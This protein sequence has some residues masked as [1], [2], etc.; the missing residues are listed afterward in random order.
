MSAKAKRLNQILEILAQEGEAEVK[1]LSEQLGVSP[2]TIRKDL[3]ELE[4]KTLIQREHGIARLRS[5]DNVAGRIAYHYDTK[6]KLAKRAA[7]LVH[8]GETVMIESG[9]CCALLAEELA[10]TKHDVTIVTNSAF[11]ADFIRHYNNINI[12][13]LGGIYEKDAQV[14]TGPLVSQ[15]AQNYFVHSFFIGTDGYSE[16]TGFTNNNQLRAQAVRDMAK[17]CDRLIILTESE[18]FHQHGS[19]PLNV[20]SRPT[21]VI[22]DSRIESDTAHTLKAHG[23]DLITVE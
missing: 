16:R 18:K 6:R 11:I 20:P 14:M 2:V 8:D 7:T 15:C 17:Q 10:Q 19:V 13:C 5:R 22:T 12:V 21:T 4:E 23:C 9:S 1:D 3:N